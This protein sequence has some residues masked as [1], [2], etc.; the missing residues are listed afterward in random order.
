MKAYIILIC[1]LTACLMLAVVNLYDATQ[2][3]EQRLQKEV[4]KLNKE[5]NHD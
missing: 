3:I 1:V 2:S 4:N 5:L